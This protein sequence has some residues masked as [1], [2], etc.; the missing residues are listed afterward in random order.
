MLLLINN[1]MSSLLSNMSFILNDVVE[2]I[3]NEDISQ[4][5]KLW[6]ESK[7]WIIAFIGGGGSLLL[8][9]IGLRVKNFFNNRKNSKLLQPLFGELSSAKNVLVELGKAMVG[10]NKEIKEIVK[11]VVKELVSSNLEQNLKNNNVVNLLVELLT[12]NISLSTSPTQ[13]KTKALDILKQ[14]NIDLKSISLLEDSIKLGKSSETSVDGKNKDVLKSIIED[15]D[16][17]FEH[18]L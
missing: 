12:V 1:F 3:V 7:T 11:S 4:L 17:E 5:A 2:P 15:N 9:D 10:D 16:D 14:L 6:Q 18:N 8:V 13:L